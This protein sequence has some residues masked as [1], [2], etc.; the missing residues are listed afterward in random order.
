V[1][2]LSEVSNEY[3]SS[4]TSKG[5]IYLT[6]DLFRDKPKFPN[7]KLRLSLPLPP[8]VNHMYFNTYKGG[9][10]LTKDAENYVRV[11]R[12]LI[13]LA[14]EEQHWIKQTKSTWFYVDLV[15]FMPDRRIRDSHNML[16][17]LLDVMQGI[18][19]DND[20]YALPRIQAVEYDTEKPRVEACIIPQSNNTR[21]KG[22]NEVKS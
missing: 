4:S 5:G 22:L 19:F 13:N 12:A 15:F 1:G 16:K 17:L 3:H 14:I 20:Y 10:K 2:K 9:K 11:S 7:K 21:E 6:N 8:S 18:V